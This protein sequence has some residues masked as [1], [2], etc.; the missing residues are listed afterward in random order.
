VMATGVPHYGLLAAYGIVVLAAAIRT[1]GERAWW[2][3]IGLTVAGT[4]VYAVSAGGYRGSAPWLTRE[5]AGLFAAAVTV[6][7][8][9]WARKPARPWIALCAVTVMA[10]VVHHTGHGATSQLSALLAT[11]DIQIT[12]LA[13]TALLFVTAREIDERDYS[14]A[15]LI[16]VILVPGLFLIAALTPLRPIAGRVPGAIVLAWAL[17]YSVGSLFERGVRRGVL[18]AA[19][20]FAGLWA[21]P[22]LLDRVSNAVPAALAAYEAAAI[23]IFT[24]A[25]LRGARRG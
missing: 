16:S 17:A 13:G 15:W 21:I 2:K 18:T 4:A 8:F 14:A 9:V 24:V 5:F 6:I 25:I 12:A 7:A 22:L 20:G 10:L 11:P 1:V 3:A 23:K 19:S